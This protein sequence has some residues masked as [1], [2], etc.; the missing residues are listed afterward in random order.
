MK[1]II[2]PY[3]ATP[4]PLG[5]PGEYPAERRWI[6][7]KDPVPDGWIEVTEEECKRRYVTHYQTVDQITAADEATKLTETRSKLSV[8]DNHF[9]AIAA[10]VAKKEAGTDTNADALA[11]AWRSAR[12]LLGI[13]RVLIE[14]ARNQS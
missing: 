10:L 11:V 13:R 2:L 8:L 12:A 3:S 9:D 6:Q 7:D 14:L 5:Y 4:N 1:L